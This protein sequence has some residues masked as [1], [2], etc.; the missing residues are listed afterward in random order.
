M[1]LSGL[2]IGLGSG[3]QG[4]A[5]YLR[6]LLERQ[7]QEQSEARRLAAGQ[8][9][10]QFAEERWVRQQQFL[11][12]QRAAE[13]QRQQEEAARNPFARLQRAMML[14][15]L[16]V[17]VEI[18]TETLGEIESALPGVRFPRAEL[19]APPELAPAPGQ[20]IAGTAVTEQIAPIRFGAP[21]AERTVTIPGLG[22]V[23]INEAVKI[24]GAEGVRSLL[25][26]TPPVSPA[27]TRLAGLAEEAKR[28][29]SFEAHLKQLRDKLDTAV[30]TKPKPD[31]EMARRVVERIDALNAQFPGL[32]VSG[33]AEF[34][35]AQERAEA[36]ELTK[37]GTLLQ[38]QKLRRG[39][40]GAAGTLTPA[41]LRV[42]NQFDEIDKRIDSAQDR[43]AT[44]YDPDDPRAKAIQQRI[45]ELDRRKAQMLRQYPWIMPFVGITLEPP[46]APGA[47]AATPEAEV[48]QAARQGLPW[49]T[50]AAALKQDGIDPTPLRAVY[51][52]ARGGPAPSVVAPTSPVAQAQRETILRLPVVQLILAR[53][54]RTRMPV[55]RVEWKQLSQREQTHLLREGV[56]VEPFRV[57]E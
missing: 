44:L 57:G 45:A 25:G 51:N 34:R 5:Q 37:A 15:Q 54:Q 8:A 18:G 19:P 46:A 27:E 1:A 55:P 23:P 36:A 21:Q 42:V 40:G 2:S 4:Y 9:A 22:P 41:Q 31:I 32:G 52:R 17:P 50:V 12:S 38:H 56:R 30:R 53:W 28:R 39:E 33:V 35:E 7:T 6:F 26:V 10:G 24:V 43:L 3:L 47:G 13:E 49:E 29:G 14:K 16:G 11:A 20:G 48:R